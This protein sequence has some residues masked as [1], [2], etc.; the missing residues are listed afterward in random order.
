MGVFDGSAA[1][2]R[3]HDVQALAAQS[4]DAVLLATRCPGAAVGVD[5]RKARFV[6]VGQLDLAGL[7]M[8]PQLVELLAGLGKGNGISLFLSCG[9]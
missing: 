9:A 2:H 8:G 4:I 1:Q 7:R 3:R 6:E 5:L